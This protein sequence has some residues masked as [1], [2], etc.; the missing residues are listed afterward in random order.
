MANKLGPLIVDVKDVPQ[1]MSRQRVLS[2]LALFIEDGSSP[3]RRITEI[4]AASVGYELLPGTKI[5]RTT[6][7]TRREPPALS[8]VFALDVDSVVLPLCRFGQDCCSHCFSLKHRTSGHARAVRFG[9]AND[10]IGHVVEMK[11]QLKPQHFKRHTAHGGEIAC[12]ILNGRFN[13]ESIV[14]TLNIPA[15]HR[16]Q[17]ASR[18]I[19]SLEPLTCLEL[20]NGLQPTPLNSR[21]FEDLSRSSSLVG[22]LKHFPRATSSK[23]L[24]PSL[25]NSFYQEA[26]EQLDKEYGYGGFEPRGTGR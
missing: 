15:R 11:T 2:C 14:R 12:R 9:H 5:F 26:I 20:E 24:E 22:S 23:H 17:L 18:G 13:S 1:E 25:Q 4:P 6:W 3:I 8:K 7:R 19:Y 16:A 10:Q 21:I